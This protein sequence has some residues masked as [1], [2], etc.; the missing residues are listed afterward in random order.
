MRFLACLMLLACNSKQPVQQ[1]PGKEPAPTKVNDPWAGSGSAEPA[2]AKDPPDVLRAKINGVNA[3]IFVLKS[4]TFSEWRDVLATVQKIPGVANAEAFTFSEL[5]IERAGRPPQLLSLKGV[6]PAHVGRILTVGRRMKSGSFDA[7]AKAGEPPPI[8]LGD[9]LASVLGAA[10]GDD[11]TVRPRKDADEMTRGAKETVF[12]VAGTFHMDFDV[13]DETL[14]F[15]PFA[16]AQAMLGKG[17]VALGIEMTVSDIKTSEQLAKAIE[18]KLG[19][20]PYQ[21]SDWYELNKNLFGAL[22]HKRP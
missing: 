22:G 16:A 12:R 4:S 14:G 5:E 1:T 8:I 6:D 11:V 19:G 18:D 7:L 15:A 2:W 10:V 9:V 13:Y 21:A 17:D 20:P 3:H